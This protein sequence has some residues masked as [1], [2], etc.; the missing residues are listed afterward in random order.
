MA[1]SNGLISAPVVHEKTT[2]DIQVVINA[3]GTDDLETL[4][5]WPYLNK[6]SKKK[7]IK[8]ARV[9][10]LEST[11][12]VMANYGIMDIPTWTRLSYIL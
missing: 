4:C 12:W 7:P 5:K 11:H 6:W 1:S 9:E 8:Y 10:A 3:V 2:G